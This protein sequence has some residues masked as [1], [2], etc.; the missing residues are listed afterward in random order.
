MI[1]IS[2]NLIRKYIVI[3]PGTIHSESVYTVAVGVHGVTEPCQINVGITGPSFNKTQNVLLDPSQLLKNV[4]FQVPVIELGDYNLTAEGV[5]C[6][7]NFKNTSRLNSEKFHNHVRIQTD[8]GTY[9]DGDTV[10][11]RVIFLDKDLRPAK[12]N[13]NATIWV[14]VNW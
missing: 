1:L 4:D 11:Y 8:K 9:K 10:N 7:G 14:E 2:L 5:N 13:E 3:G 6:I 12:P